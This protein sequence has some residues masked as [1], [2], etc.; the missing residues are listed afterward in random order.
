MTRQLYPHQTRA[1]HLL[2]RSLLAGNTRVMLQ[3]PTGFGKTVVM[4]AIVRGALGKGNRV[5]VVAPAIELIDQTVRSF[6]FEGIHAVGVM[7][8]LHLMTDHTQPVQVA[9]VQTL[10]NR[11][12]PAAD[13]V[14]IDEAHRWFEFYSTFMADPDWQRVPIIGLSATPWT[15][16]LGRH[17]QDLIIAATTSELI[18]AGYLSRFGCS[19]PLIPISAGSA[20]SRATSTRVS[21]ARR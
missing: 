6:R 1:L 4:G 15:K 8:G 3:A 11:K 7:Q 14:V 9:S 19:L 13:V 12:L 18:E 17:F 5:L 21:L 10:A 2:K 16:G 20:P